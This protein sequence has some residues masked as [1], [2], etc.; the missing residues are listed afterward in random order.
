MAAYARRAETRRYALAQGAADEAFDT[1]AEAVRNA[2]VVVICTPVRSIPALA[3]ECRTSMKA[4]CVVTDVGSTKE[5][6]VRGME[7][8]FRD[9]RQH[10]VGSHPMA[11]SEKTGMEAARAD[12]YRNAV[13]AVT[14]SAAS[15]EQAVRAV[16]DLWTSVGARAIGLDAKEHDRLVARTSHLPHLVAACLVASVGRELSGEVR[17]FCGTG[18]RDTTRIASGSADLWRD[19]V[20]TN[21]AAVLAELQGCSK[22]LQDVIA[23][24]E[25]GDFEGLRVYLE[26]ARAVREKLVGAAG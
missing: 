10:F 3:G 6:V 11:G 7:A 20:E 5:E 24:I 26:R 19:I 13:V 17:G 2:D 21:R 25:K 15:S 14:P 23:I 9:G 4:G 12:L 8:L 22:E 18:F 16:M 1:P